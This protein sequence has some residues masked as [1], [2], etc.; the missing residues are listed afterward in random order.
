MRPAGSP[1]K[2]K[3][4]GGFRPAPEGRQKAIPTVILHGRWYE[5]DA[6]APAGEPRERGF[7]FDFHGFCPPRCSDPVGWK[8]AESARRAYA[9]QAHGA[10]FTAWTGWG[11][12][13]HNHAGGDDAR[14]MPA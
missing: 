11:C 3:E 8:Q 13:R 7:G 14:D 2:A 5:R 6:Q 4:T 1:A 10:F 12:E 9:S